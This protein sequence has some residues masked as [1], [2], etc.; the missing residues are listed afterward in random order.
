MPPRDWPGRPLARRRTA[1]ALALAMM[2]A[3]GLT[4]AG[5]DGFAPHRSPAPAP[6]TWTHFLSERGEGYLLSSDTEGTWYFQPREWRNRKFATSQDLLACTLSTS[7]SG[8]T[9]FPRLGDI[10][11]DWE[12]Y[13]DSGN[14]GWWRMRGANG[15]L[16][17]QSREWAGQTFV[18]VDALSTAIDGIAA[19]AA[20][21]GAPTVNYGIQHD[22]PQQHTGVFSGTAVEQCPDGQLPDRAAGMSQTEQGLIA[23]GAGLLAGILLLGLILWLQRRTTP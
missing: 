10:A 12:L 1:A 17:W 2:L 6:A 19:K 20:A 8:L 18:S 21:S 23:A 11:S 15:D 9:G 14:K 5:L 7:Y 3:G 13:V 16:Y 22:A 4:F